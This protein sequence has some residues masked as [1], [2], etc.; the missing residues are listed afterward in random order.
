MLATYDSFEA[1]EFTVALKDDCLPSSAASTVASSETD[2]LVDKETPENNGSLVDGFLKLLGFSSNPLAQQQ[3]DAQ[4]INNAAADMR[5]SMLS[6]FS[7]A[8][9]IV[10]ISLSLHIMDHIYSATA[11]DESI[12]SSALIAG[13][14]IGQFGGGTLGDVLGRHRAMGLV[15]WLQ[16]VASFGSACSVPLFQLSIFQVLAIWRFILGLGCG[17]VYPLAATLTAESSQSKE[18][19]GKNVALTFSLQ[20]VG[21]L[22]VPILAWSIVSILGEE[23]DIGWRLILGG[24]CVPGVVLAILRS[25]RVPMQKSKEALDVEAQA[26]V[27]AVPVS[28]FDAILAE[29]DLVKKFLGTGGCCGCL[30]FYSMAIH[31]SSPWFCPPHSVQPKRYRKRPEIQA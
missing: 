6:N 31:C 29:E 27:R 11:Q 19:R 14:I 26:R 8:Y 22:A 23:S 9:N 15:M 10:S 3:N 2:H 5:L 17:G 16:V 30:I 28:V 24:G 21:Y 18:D 13:M 7:S 4:T 12:C 25:N 1:E 20:G